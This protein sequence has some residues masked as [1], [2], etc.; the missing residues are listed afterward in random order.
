MM[1]SSRSGRS[2]IGSSSSSSSSRYAASPRDL[3]HRQQL[4][5]QQQQQ[6]HQQ[7]HFQP[8]QQQPRLQFSN[9]R[10]DSIPTPRPGGWAPTPSTRGSTPNAGSGRHRLHHAATPSGGRSERLHAGT[11]SSIASGRSSATP[12]SSG[13]GEQEKTSAVKVAVRVRPF[14]AAE[15]ADGCRA[16]VH[17]QNQSTY[18]VDPAGLG[19]SDEDLYTR[20][21]CY[22]YSYWSFDKVRFLPMC[23]SDGTSQLVLCGRNGA[24]TP[25]RS[26]VLTCGACICLDSFPHM[27]SLRWCGGFVPV[28]LTP[29]TLAKIA[30]S[31]ILECLCWRTLSKATT[32]PCLRMGKRELE[33]RTR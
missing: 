14:S 17:M 20:E 5:Q 33:S 15:R 4:Q 10:N 1:M 8:N 12:R 3:H 2:K 6:Q 25:Q 13:Q 21:F 30:Y 32:A 27:L 26:I 18:L 7:Q 9:H 16:I 19:A 24:D 28:S 31:K 29:A 23:C 22:D 11:P